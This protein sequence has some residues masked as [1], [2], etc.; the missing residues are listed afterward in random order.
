MGQLP[1]LINTYYPGADIPPAKTSWFSL[2]VQV[3]HQGYQ[4]Y[5][6]SGIY[7]LGGLMVTTRILPGKTR[8]GAPQK[9]TLPSEASHLHAVNLV[10]PKLGGMVGFYSSEIILSHSLGCRLPREM[11]IFAQS[12]TRSLQNV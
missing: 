4:L 7:P 10:H 8:G 11:K 5:H 1:D 2:F 3:L 12:A 6:W 9:A